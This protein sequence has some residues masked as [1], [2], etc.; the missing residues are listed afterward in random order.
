MLFKF[1][2]EIESVD[3]V[4][5]QLLFAPSRDDAPKPKEKIT[6]EVDNFLRAL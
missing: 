3:D 5:G 1:I 6:K 2:F 4:F